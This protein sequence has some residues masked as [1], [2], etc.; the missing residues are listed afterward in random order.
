M[1]TPKTALD[2]TDFR[3]LQALQ[4]DAR[5][6]SAE[7]AER[8]ALSPS[9]CWRRVKRLEED[10]VILGYHAK[11]DE[12]QLGFHLKA[13]VHV[14]LDKKDHAH[15]RLFEEAVRANAQILACYCVSGRYDHQLVVV[16]RTMEEFGD[17]VRLQVGALPNVKEVYTAFVLKEVKAP[18]EALPDF[19]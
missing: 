2:R 4:N 8:V 7:L 12:K 14:S 16:A 15:V 3:I 18:T 1:N 13:F 19:S 11:V 10:G 9:P 17:F 5:L 6:S